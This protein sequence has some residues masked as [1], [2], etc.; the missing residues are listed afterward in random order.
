M[1]CL[2]HLVYTGE[3]NVVSAILVDTLELYGRVY[4]LATA[5]EEDAEVHAAAP[6]TLGAAARRVVL[7]PIEKLE[8]SSQP[9][10]TNGTVISVD[11]DDEDHQGDVE[12]ARAQVFKRRQSQLLQMVQQR[13]EKGKAASPT[14]GSEIGHSNGTAAKA[15]W[16][17][18]TAR[19]WAR[20]ARREH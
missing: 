1:Y 16:Q 17:T 20:E 12:K 11:G 10:S 13:V 2:A 8:F 9:A 5:A 14:N 19:T 15:Q 3:A 18:H 7:G 4:K 6:Q